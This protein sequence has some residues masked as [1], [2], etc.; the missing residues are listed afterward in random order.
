MFQNKLIKFVL[1]LVL[2]GG[3]LSSC[4][5]EKILKSTNYRLKYKKALQYYHEKDY[6]RA[7]GLLEQINPALKAT[8][9]ADTVHYYLADSYYQ[10]GDYILAKHYFN[11]FYQTFGN[12]DWSEEAEFLSAYCDYKMSPRPSLEQSHTKR[13]ING[14]QLFIRRHPNSPKVKQCNDLIKEL[15]N[16]LAIKAYNAAKLY[17]EMEDYKAA[18]IALNN[19]L[20]RYPN[21]KHREEI[22]FLILKS[23]FLLAS[24]S[25]RS[26]EQQRFQSTLDEYYTFINQYPDSEYQNEVKEIY[27]ETQRNL[28]N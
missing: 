2:F 10:Q 21:T 27:K 8:D 17:Y 12:H 1:I 11:E 15:R 16:K 22:R 19:C 7:I 23:N 5:Y 20:K 26:K 13:A 14:F 24:N 6:S 4:E 18:I 9:R 28:K 25:I 3:I